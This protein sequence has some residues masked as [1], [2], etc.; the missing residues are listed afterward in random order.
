MTRSERVDGSPTNPSRWLERLHTLMDATAIKKS[1]LY[2]GKH[3]KYASMLNNIDGTYPVDRPKPNRPVSARP[4]QLSLTKIET[5]IRDPYSVY[6]EKIL[7]LKKLKMINAMSDMSD[8]GMIVHDILEKWMTAHQ[9]DVSDPN[10]INFNSISQNTLRDY[11]VDQSTVMAWMPRLLRVGEWF[12]NHEEIWRNEI[13]WSGSEVS[14]SMRIGDNF[15]LTARADRIDQRID[16]TYAI[17]DYKSG[18]QFT[19]SA[20]KAARSPQLPLEAIILDNKGFSDINGYT[21]YLGY[22]TMTGGTPAG[23]ITAVDSLDDVQKSANLTHKSLTNLIEEFQ[24]EETPYI[25]LPRSN[26]AP[27]YNDYLYLA[28]VKEWS[29]LDDSELSEAA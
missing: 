19:V 13:T 12:V 16:G 24:K 15:I 26:V 17:V 5:L 27:R 7:K 4:T 6:A 29:V 23:K 10:L 8:R 3:H 28:R 18:G 22:W 9:S 21:S 14:G 2:N 11:G 1:A 20:L 25:S